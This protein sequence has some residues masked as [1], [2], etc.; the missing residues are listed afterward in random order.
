M[1]AYA[2]EE[3]KLGAAFDPK[4]FRRLLTYTRPHR[5][6]FFYALG[7]LAVI[8]LNEL[9]LPYLT[10]T[11]IDSVILPR[12]QRQIPGINLSLEQLAGV[13]FAILIV[14]FFLSYV[15][16]LV[17][18]LSG[19]R[20]V[21]DI[22]NQ[23]YSKLMELPI[24]YFQEA[25]VGR[26]VTRVTN[27]V[28]AVY[29]MYTAV[30]V[31]LIKDVIVIFG[32]LFILAHLNLELAIGVIAF[33][34]LMAWISVIFKRMAR[35]AYRECRRKL[36]ALNAFLNE[37]VSG[38]RIV[39]L[40][41][42]QESSAKEFASIN[43]EEYL[44]NIHQLSVYAVFQPLIAL[45]SA[46]ALAFVITWGCGEVVSQ[47]FTIGALT[48]YIG[49]LEMLFSPIRDLAEK[50]NI[51]QGAVASAERVFILLD[52]P[53]EPKIEAEKKLSGEIEFRSVWS[54]YNPDQWVLKDVS[55]KVRPGERVA[56]V[57][58]T[59]A[60]KSTVI[61]LLLRFHDHQKG[62]ILIDGI[63]IRELP[64]NTLRSSIGTVLQ[65]VFL[66]SDTLLNNLKLKSAV[67]PEKV[68]RALEA[69][70]AKQVLLGLPDGLETKV[71]ERGGTLSMGQRQLL[72]LARAVLFDPKIII[73]DEA[74][75]HIDSH[76]ESLLQSG[77]KEVFKERTALIIAHRL[78][79][80]RQADRILVFEDGRIVE[81]GTH[82]ELL[83]KGTLYRA[84]YQLQF[85]V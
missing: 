64:L 57:G 46:V 66:F 44:A 1:T 81:D 31:Y 71:G 83:E 61:S 8:S 11:A 37:R 42:A 36:A 39:Q 14:R 15:L 65:D 21:R 4:V 62:E 80:V 58:P 29:E 38:M 16:A 67:S 73:L 43:Q 17:L 72:Q 3:E 32:A 30:L 51:L 79:T 6:L 63:N 20:I 45:L 77:L 28:A 26:L 12:S 53:G 55:F 18:Q 47:T 35:L 25:P 78:S 10:K 82:Q 49:Y 70:Q 56:I 48:A 27:D 59:G 85:A 24:S 74:T 40:F 75:S 19:Q 23:I 33:G 76:T 34:P 52:Q 50:Y 13:M 9:S 84:L 68:E 60:G 69:S 7:V 5:A 2:G 54:Q 22:R 41:G